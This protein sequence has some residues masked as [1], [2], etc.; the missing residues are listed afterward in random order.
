MFV[1]LNAFEMELDC[2]GDDDATDADEDD[3]ETDE[4]VD[5]DELEV[6]AV[7]V[8][9]EIDA[10]FEESDATESEDDEVMN[11]ILNAGAIEGTKGLKVGADEEA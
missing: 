11:P 7:N 1:E 9:A 2:D 6:D 10:G 3:H 5:D 4:V 8:V